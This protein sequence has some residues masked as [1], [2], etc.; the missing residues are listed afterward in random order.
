MPSRLSALDNQIKQ[1]GET[2]QSYI[3]YYKYKN[4]GDKKPGPVRQ[5]RIYA[6]SYDEARQLAT[7][8]ANY[9]N[10]EVL[11]IKEA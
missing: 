10:I 11:R 7:Q 1:V 3:I 6:G 8:Y 4:A 5:Y 2:M 9:P